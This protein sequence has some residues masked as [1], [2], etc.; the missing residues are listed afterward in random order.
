MDIGGKWM[1][2]EAKGLNQKIHTAAGG[3][4]FLIS[5]IVYFLTVAPTTS[6]WDCGEFIACS[7]TLSVMHP[8]GAPLYLVIG[9]ILTI[10]PFFGDIGLRVNLFA[11]L[12]SVATVLLTYLIIVQLI[13]RWRGKAASW[14]DRL[15][16]Y[17]SGV[18]GALAFAFT[19]SFWFNAV[20]AEVYSFSMFFTALVVWLALYW[21]ERS[22]KAGSLLIILFI[23][24]IFGLATGVHLLNILTFPFVLLIA[25]FHDNQSVRRLLLLLTIQAGVPI[26]LY[27]VFYQFDAQKMMYSNLILAH[28]EKASSFLKW[29]GL[30]WISGTMVY[31]YFK[32]RTVFRIW[33]TLPLLGLIAYSTYLVIYIRAGLSPPINENDPSTVGAM[34]DYLAR[35][36][37]GTDDLLLTFLHRKGDFW[38]YQI[39]KMYTRYFGWQFIGKGIQLDARDRILEIISF[40]GLYCL[41]FLV[42]LWGSVH[43]FFK[44][45]KRAVAVL[46][47]FFL[48]GFGIILYVNQHDPQPRERDYSYVGSFFAF[49]LWIGIGMVGILEWI[50][51]V[52]K[53]REKMMRMV[54]GAV[55]VLL[56]IAVP[57]NMLAFNYDSHD[58]SGNYVAWDYSYNILQS[59]EPD[60]IVFTNGDNDTFPL[61]YLQ[62]VEGIRKDVRVICLSLLNTHW[63][64][65]QL[66]DQE[67]KV[68]MSL[69]E[70]AINNLFPIGWE[71]SQVGIS[72]PKDVQERER[73]I[74]MDKLGSS[75]VAQEFPDTISFTLS[76]T[77]PETNPQGI[78][79][80]DLM[81]L[82]ILE[83]NRWKRPV[84]FAVTV[85]HTNQLNLD[86]YLRMDGLAYRV[87]PY[88]VNQVD[89]QVLRE[90]LLEKFQY[91]GLDD[92][93][94]FFN[95]GTVKLL[96]NVRQ[97]FLQLA[98]YHFNHG[99]KDDAAFV[100]EEMAK[101]VPEENIPYAHERI[102]LSVSEHYNRAGLDPEYGKRMQ[103]V[104]PGR[105][106]TSQ[107]RVWIAGYYTQVIQD[108]EK[109]EEMF[110]QLI[111]E[112]KNDVQAYSGLVQ[113]Y[114]LSR[115]YDQAVVLLED[116]LMRH[117]TDPNAQQELE[118]LRRLAVQ[119]STG[120]R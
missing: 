43:H 42:G 49:A 79:V 27:M 46:L 3:F 2:T 41:P 101:R 65:R 1:D 23:F 96:I 35:K 22:S 91:R 56:F 102:A 48:M 31:I 83:A 54:C 59:C 32:D 51:D 114:R 60:G 58:R 38:Q 81:V 26:L 67:P 21:G 90:N 39:H 20:E 12:I 8:P 18:F 86:R 6:F 4:V 88:P 25:L 47:L 69:S 93:D 14:E 77:F 9:R 36:Q 113:T 7:K 117:P 66:R 106:L 52:L 63:Y 111:Q 33:W 107:D 15:I 80:Q 34:M 28:Q 98:R 110:L 64:I 115:K 105:Q 112:N 16:L 11:V 40:R 82:R 45:W 109:A 13:E 37:Y 104:I 78:R 103:H 76:P 74:L 119:D 17:A 44:D 73:K 118:D 71:R 89:P 94:V 116:W 24:Y 100:L 19:D 5:L 29:F 99:Q 108:Y 61:W 120:L 75:I 70:R 84:Y 72:V 95:V 30:I 55:V 68:P 10:L 85:S 92:P 50:V 62:E 87:M 97:A 53:G 57:I